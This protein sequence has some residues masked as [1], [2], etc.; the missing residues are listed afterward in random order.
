MGWNKFYPVVAFR[1][2][3]LLESL[4]TRTLPMD[5]ERSSNS[6]GVVSGH[7]CEATEPGGSSAHSVRI[8]D[9]IAAIR[10]PNRCR[11][12][13]RYARR[14]PKSSS[15]PRLRHKSR[16]PTVR[17]TRAPGPE[18]AKSLE[19]R[20]LNRYHV[21][22]VCQARAVWGMS[23]NTSMRAAASINRLRAGMLQHSCGGTCNEAGS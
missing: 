4:S 9:K 18:R 1:S 19:S 6:E 8:S 20:K 16:L 22:S 11:R 10:V 21:R 13:L 5:W 2:R 14:T 12:G 15:S 7:P 3:V 23:D 17:T